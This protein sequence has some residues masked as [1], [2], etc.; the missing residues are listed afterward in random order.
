MLCKIQGSMPCFGGR[1]SPALWF[2]GDLT[3]QTPDARCPPKDAK[4]QGGPVRVGA[5]SRAGLARPEALQVASP[6]SSP[7]WGRQSRGG[8][9]VPPHGTCDS[10]DG[11]AKRHVLSPRNSSHCTTSDFVCGILQK[12]SSP[13]KRGWRIHHWRKTPLQKNF[14]HFSSL[15]FITIQAY[16][17]KVL[18]SRGGKAQYSNQ[19]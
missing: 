11:F 17:S 12:L 4:H 10:Y 19:F 2:K 8:T 14:S 15:S 13:P 9:S 18:K 7:G 6:P 5:P 3:L 16:Y 1:D